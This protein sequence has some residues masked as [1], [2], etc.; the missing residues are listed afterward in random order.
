MAD[1]VNL[2]VDMGRQCFKSIQGFPIDSA[3]RYLAF[4]SHVVKRKEEYGVLVVLGATKDPRFKDNA[5]VMEGPRSGS[6]LELRWSHGK[7]RESLAC[8]LSMWNHIQKI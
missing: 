5:L 1:R 3:P 4:C 2:V 6:T 8:A 7:V